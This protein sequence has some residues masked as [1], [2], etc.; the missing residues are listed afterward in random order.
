VTVKHRIGLDEG[1]SYAFVRDFVGT[2]AVGGCDVFIVHARNAVLKGLSPKEN[3]EVPPLR[4]DVV[5]Q[6]AVDFPDKTFVINGGLG[7]WRAVDRELG[8]VDGV[9]LGRLAYHNPWTLQ[10]ADA[11]LFDTDP[12]IATRADA[13][14]AFRP[15]VERQLARGVPLRAMTRHIL[16]LYLG[17]PGGRRFRQILSDARRMRDEGI[18]VLDAALQ[19]VEPMAEFA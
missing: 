3:R 9:M 10:Q 1:V 2:V 17:Q 13:L 11:R 7:D 5:H 4:Y 16:G 14:R 19:A 12:P 8:M 18:A 6:L 15:Y